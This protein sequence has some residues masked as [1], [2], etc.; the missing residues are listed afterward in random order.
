MIISYLFFFFYKLLMFSL[1]MLTVNGN[2]FTI[3]IGFPNIIDIVL[4]V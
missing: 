1:L 4:K 3:S 2:S